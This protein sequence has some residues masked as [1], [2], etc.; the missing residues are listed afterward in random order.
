LKATR[1]ANADSAKAQ[2]GTFVFVVGPL[3]PPIQGAAA[4]TQDIVTYTARRL[5]VY[6]AN[7]ARGTMD[8]LRGHAVKIG[9]VLRAMTQLLLKAANGRSRVLYMAADGGRGIAYNIA[10]ASVA[11]LCGYRIFLHHHSFAYIDHPSALMATLVRIM[12][13][14][15]VHIVLCDFM[16]EALRARYPLIG[17]GAT[18]QLSGAAFLDIVPRTDLRPGNDLQIGFLSNLIV[19]KGLDTSIELVRAARRENLPV[20]LLLAGKSPDRRSAD[21]VQSAK[22]ELGSAIEYLG[23]LTE[24]EKTA[25][26]HNIDAFIFPTRYVNEAQP[27]AILEALAFGVPVLTVAR[28]CITGDVGKG[29]GMCVPRDANFVATVL[30]LVR[31]WCAN[32]ESLARSGREALAR[33]AELRKNSTSH[34]A[35]IVEAFG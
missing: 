18:M 5:P 8:G 15:G 30:P 10:V 2:S 29:S 34:L 35:E 12:G 4:A 19:E 13:R 31:E 20:R 27:R 25:F 21:M 17:D 9:R 24:E 3:P 32:R 6:A 7:V 28:S 1:I 23:P 26:F 16:A 33:A 14:R 22:S 11:R